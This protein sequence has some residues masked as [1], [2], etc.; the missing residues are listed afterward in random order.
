[1]VY[2]NPIASVKLEV[3]T[4]GW[5]DKGERIEPYDLNFVRVVAAGV[6]EDVPADPYNSRVEHITGLLDIPA[7]RDWNEKLERLR[8]PYPS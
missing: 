6:P 4:L 7:V 5:T 2:A 1:M 3:Q 8:R